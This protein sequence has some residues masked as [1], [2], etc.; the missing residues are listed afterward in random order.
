LALGGRDPH[1]LCPRFR[2]DDL[3][4]AHPHSSNAGSA[5]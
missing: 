4:Q 3:E 1:R 2:P 5:L